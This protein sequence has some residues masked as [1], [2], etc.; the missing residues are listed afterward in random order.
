MGEE[1][2]KDSVGGQSR[3]Q[4]VRE[5]MGGTGG[6]ERKKQTYEAEFISVI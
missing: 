6:G 1:G 5:R 3:K 4:S 2:G